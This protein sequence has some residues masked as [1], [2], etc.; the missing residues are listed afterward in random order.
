MRPYIQETALLDGFG[1]GMRRAR[2]LRML[3]HQGAL[4]FEIWTGIKPPIS[5]MRDALEGSKSGK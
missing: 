4:A 5:V 2:R 1:Q 3:L